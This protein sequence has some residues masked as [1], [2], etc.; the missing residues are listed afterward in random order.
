MEKES[1]YLSPSQIEKK[2]KEAGIGLKETLALIEM[3]WENTPEQSGLV[4]FSRLFKTLDQLTHYTVKG[5]R[6][7]R[8]RSKGPNQPFQVIEVYTPGKEV[9]AYLNMVYL[10]KPL[11]CY[12]LVYVEVTPSFRGK[13]LGNR[14]L[15]AFRDF[16]EGKGALG[17]LDNIIPPEDPTFDIYTRLGWLPIEALI[18]L[19]EEMDQAHYMVY[20]PQNLKKAL[21]TLKLPKLLFNLKKKRPIIEMQDNESMVRRTIQEFNEIYGA[22]KRLFQKELEEGNH[23]PLMRFMF[24]KFTTRLLGFQR[25]IQELL[26][27]TGGESLEQIK[28]SPRVRALQILP[29]T[30]DP[31]GCDFQLSG[32]KALWLALPQDMTANPTRTIEGLLPYQ[33]PF[34]RQWV[35]E[36]HK[37]EPL[38]LTIADLLDLGFDPTRLREFSFRDTHYMFERLSPLLLRETEDRKGLLEKIERKTRGLRIQQAQIRINPPLLWIQ[39]RGNGYILRARLKGIHWEEAVFQLKQNPAHRWVN[40]QLHLDRKITAI[41]NEI[42]GWIATQIRMPHQEGLQDLAF[43]VP[44]NLD[45]NSPL[46]SIDP[47]NAPYLETVWVA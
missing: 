42:K 13:G 15:E 30:F 11:P 22:L 2:F 44:W 4:P 8:F 25:R 9:L 37:T 26:G 29:Y 24:T 36:N 16:V 7:K 32:D 21:L 10:R 38:H 14:I 39:D 20:I 35:E 6:I 34:L 5:S 17:L 41:I 19:G 23:T 3:T 45:R 33:R 18:G 46:F 47:A 28:L 40:Q 43:F 27:Y 12:Y 1:L 31:A